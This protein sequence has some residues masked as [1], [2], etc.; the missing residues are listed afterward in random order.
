MHDIG[1]AII[2][3]LFFI[4]VVIVLLGCIAVLII[5][6]LAMIDEKIVEDL[7]KNLSKFIRRLI[8]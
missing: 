7:Q 5:A 8:K 4:A 1:M 3:T 6:C 2:G